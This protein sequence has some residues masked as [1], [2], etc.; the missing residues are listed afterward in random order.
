MRDSRQL[1]LT[2]GLLVA[3]AACKKPAP[4]APVPEP[5]VA[6]PLAAAG[7]LDEKWTW[8]AVSFSKAIAL[9]QRGRSATDCDVTC[10]SEGQPKWTLAA[11]IASKDDFTFLA[12]DCSTVLVLLEYP[13]KVDGWR[14][15]PV[16][17][18]LRNGTAVGEFSGAQLV[19][20][21]SRIKENGAHFRW[22]AGALGE[23]GAAPRYLSDGLGVQFE[24][25]DGRATT[26][27][28]ADVMVALAK[29]PAAPAARAVAGPLGPYE[30]EDEAGDTHFV[31]GLSNVPAKYRQRAHPVQGEVAVMSGAEKQKA[32]DPASYLRSGAAMPPTPDMPAAPAQPA[33]VARPDDGVER[34]ELG[35]TPRDYA[36]RMGSHGRIIMPNA[37]KPSDPGQCAAWK[38]A[39]GSNKDC[40]SQRCTGG[41]CE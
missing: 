34:N 38:A 41:A 22:L 19:A 30:Y 39:C 25:I 9:E 27:R 37:P 29:A 23:K 2:F 5:A 13:K 16:L 3:L 15:A 35:E 21:A 11:C 8:R 1:T 40:C 7:P 24:A 17:R 14:T 10:G 12:E 33:A 6:P 4:E 20:D 36:I 28:F 26:L 18:V 32:T 31:D